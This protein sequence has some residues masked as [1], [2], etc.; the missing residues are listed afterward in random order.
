LEWTGAVYSLT[1]EDGVID[2]GTVALNGQKTTL[3]LDPV[4]TQI[5]TNTGST[6]DF[7][8][9]STG[10]T[11][12]GTSWTLTTATGSDYQF[13]HK[14]STDGGG[15]WITFANPDPFTYDLAYNVIGSDT[16][17]LDLFIGMPSGTD[18]YNAKSITV[19]IQAGAP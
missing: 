3:D 15:A 11:G 6:A 5:V 9:M 4:D 16:V 1:V 14:F 2:Y 17:A 13:I 19:T 8:I 10:A 7:T 18:D 12:S